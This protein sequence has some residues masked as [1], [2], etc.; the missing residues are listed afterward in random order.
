[1]G[2]VGVAEQA[3]MNPAG[4]VQCNANN[5][6]VAPTREICDTMAWMATVFF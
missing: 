3:G 6:S 2:A 5:R 4:G 1:M